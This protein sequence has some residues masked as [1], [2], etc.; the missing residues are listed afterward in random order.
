MS[1]TPDTPNNKTPT[2]ARPS[3]VR[4]DDV[5]RTLIDEI[6]ESVAELKQ[7]ITRAEAAALGSEAQA[8]AVVDLSVAALSV[9][10]DGQSIN[11]YIDE[12]IEREPIDPDDEL[13]AD[14]DLGPEYESPIF[15]SLAEAAR[16]TGLAPTTL[17]NQIHNGRL[18]AMKL[19]RNW[20]VTRASVEA[21]LAS[22]KFNA[23]PARL[24]PARRARRRR[25]A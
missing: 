22:R 8:D 18:K 17:R 13:T 6:Q 4:L 11:D 15:M 7:H 14:E 21:Y 5:L 10:A 23:K 19:A 9:S 25:S 16:A 12:L 1:N 3:E 2:P 20:I 24:K